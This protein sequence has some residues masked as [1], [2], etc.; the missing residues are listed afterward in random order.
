M[1]K[2]IAAAAASAGLLTFGLGAT[3]AQG[4][5][6]A[7]PDAT[8]QCGSGCTNWHAAGNEYNTGMKVIL[9]GQAPGATLTGAPSGTPVISRIASTTAWR[10]DFTDADVGKVRRLVRAGLLPTGTYVDINYGGQKAFQIQ[11]TPDGRTT[12]MCVGTMGSATNG[13]K[14]VLVPCG[15]SDTFW[16]VDKTGPT[17]TPGS[18]HAL[19]PATGQNTSN[20]LALQAPSAVG[21]Q[22]KVSYE[23]VS[24][25]N[26][27]EA[28]GFYKTT[29]TTF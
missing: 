8:T 7:H 24:V 21:D 12:N 22:L 16:V 3:A 17:T 27:A 25:G 15:K 2:I 1:R 26:L 29:G 4:A 18:Y 14:V 9:A 6:S 28:Y 11:Y 20:P 10:E 13:A 5:V 19:L 23:A